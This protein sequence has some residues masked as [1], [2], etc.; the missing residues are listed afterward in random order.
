MTSFYWTFWT[1]LISM[2]WTDVKLN[3]GELWTF[4]SRIKKGTAGTK[5]ELEKRVWERGVWIWDPL[6]AIL[7]DE[8]DT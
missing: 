3:T 4:F 2:E 7:I 5:S 1:H 8:I 6:A